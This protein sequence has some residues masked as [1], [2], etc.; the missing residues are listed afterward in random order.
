MC[1]EHKFG[2]KLSVWQYICLKKPVSI[3]LE[4]KKIYLQISPTVGTMVKL[5]IIALDFSK[6]DKSLA[7]ILTCNSQNSK[8]YV[9]CDYKKDKTKDSV[10][11]CLTIPSSCVSIAST[12]VSSIILLTFFPPEPMIK[13]TFSGLTYEKN[14]VMRKRH[15]TN[16]IISFNRQRIWNKP[17]LRE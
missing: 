7:V 4:E 2:Q 5:A 13:F 9:T 16:Q 12:P 17:S 8:R 10:L 15:S 1:I 11:F 3:F 14:E 6:L